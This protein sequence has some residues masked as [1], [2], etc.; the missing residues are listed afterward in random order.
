MEIALIVIFGALIAGSWFLYGKG[1]FSITPKENE[2]IGGTDSN[3]PSQP[4]EPDKPDEGLSDI[5][6]RI[7]NYSEKLGNV[8]TT[9]LSVTKAISK[10]GLRYGVNRFLIAAIAAQESYLGRVLTGDE[11]KSL[12]P[13]HVYRPTYDW[14][15]YKTGWSDD[16]S[17][18]K[19]IDTGIKYGTYFLNECIKKAMVK[20]KGLEMKDYRKISAY[21]YNHGLSSLDNKTVSEA[22]NIAE[23]DNYV[24]RV[25]EHYDKI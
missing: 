23:N 21:L 17:S 10:Y 9:A 5:E 15:R 22:L 8:S 1:V 25:L 14:I 13:M 18:L 6:I 24:K 20:F 2:G 16:W 3:V 12:G 7:K 19:G 4:N 11:G